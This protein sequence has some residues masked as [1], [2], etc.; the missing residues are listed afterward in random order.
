MAISGKRFEALDKEY[1]VA[2]TSVSKADPKEILNTAFNAL[3]EVAA[4][5]KKAADSMKEKADPKKAAAEAKKAVESAQKASGLD[6]VLSSA[7]EAASSVQAVKNTVRQVQGVMRSTFDTS[8]LNGKTLDRFVSEIFSGDSISQNLFKQIRSGNRDKAI[9]NIT[10]GRPIRPVVKKPTPGNP[11]VPTYVETTPEHDHY[12]ISEILDRVSGNQYA[13]EPV[14]NNAIAHRSIVVANT[15]YDAGMPDVMSTIRLTPNLRP[16]VLA[17]TTAV[18]LQEQAIKGNVDAVVDIAANTAPENA[19][20]LQA[21]SAI[22]D[23]VAHFKIPGRRKERDHVQLA[24]ETI[25]ALN[26][27]DPQWKRSKQDN[28]ISLRHMGSVSKDF[29]GT[30]Q[31]KVMNN[32]PSPTAPTAVYNTEHDILTAAASVRRDDI[33]RRLDRMSYTFECKNILCDC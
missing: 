14:D 25:A 15:A 16:Q 17:R 30:M 5:L 8:K 32:I 1:N 33:V 11:T 4:A 7:G 23:T 29:V 26:A 2:M 10:T 19:P 28:K 12:Q 31:T 6:K 20:L 13:P 18:V 21:P 9:A 24:V 27:L 22:Q 3:K